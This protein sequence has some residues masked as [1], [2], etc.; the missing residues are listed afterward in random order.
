MLDA[1]SW[2]E[3]KIKM[4]CKRDKKGPERENITTLPSF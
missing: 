2:L 3:N 4:V 1:H